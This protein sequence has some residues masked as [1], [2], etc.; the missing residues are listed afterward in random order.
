MN[1][2]I[3][4]GTTAAYLYSVAA[5]FVPSFF[6]SAGGEAAVYYDTA[7]IIIAL[8]LMGRWMEARARGR[9]SDAIASLLGLQPKSAR[10][11]R[12]GAEVMLPVESVLPDD[13]VA[14]RPGERLPVDG[15][16][17]EGAST[18]DESML[19]GRKH[20]RR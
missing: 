12:D 8:I 14:V 13:I 18:I 9:A 11:M 3:S 20:P 7:I 19:T 5:T 17:T 16:V 15:I 1:T 10:V 6:E 4:L 2:L